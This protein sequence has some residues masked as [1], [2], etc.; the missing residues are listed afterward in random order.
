M[1]ADPL[2]VSELAL[3]D[4]LFVHGHGMPGSNDDEFGPAAGETVVLSEQALGMALEAARARLNDSGRV[5]I[6]FQSRSPEVQRWYR[7]WLDPGCYRA[8]M[9]RLQAADMPVTLQVTA[10]SP[11]DTLGGL[12]DTLRHAYA[13]RPGRVEVAPLTVPPGSFFDRHHDE[14]ALRV[15]PTPPFSVISHAQADFVSVRRQVLLGSASARSYN[16]WRRQASR[17]P[18][19]R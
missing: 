4:S 7:R 3:V 11:G 14:F 12:L 15:E 8:L 13:L 9:Q 16:Y 19:D 18:F 10:G 2:P 6:R 5:I 1:G 17:A